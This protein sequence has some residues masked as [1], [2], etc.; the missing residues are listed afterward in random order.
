[1]SDGAAKPQTNGHTN[2]TQTQ[3]TEMPYTAHRYTANESTHSR[4][5]LHFFWLSLAPRL[6]SDLTSISCSFPTSYQY[7][8]FNLNFPPK[9]D[10]IIYPVP[11]SLT[12]LSQQ[13]TPSKSFLLSPA[14]TSDF[15]SVPQNLSS[16]PRGPQIPEAPLPRTSPSPHQ[17]QS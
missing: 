3:H 13:I 16:Y 6:K 8:Y 11:S 5:S 1:M 12:G 7:L 17:S 9:R 14:H 2:N 4:H 10:K 15:C